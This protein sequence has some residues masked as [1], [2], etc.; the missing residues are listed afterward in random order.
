MWWQHNFLPLDPA[1]RPPLRQCMFDTV[2]VV[3][4]W[5]GYAVFIGAIALTLAPDRPLWLSILLGW[6]FP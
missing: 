6:V 3:V 4:G 5:L 2:F 1:M